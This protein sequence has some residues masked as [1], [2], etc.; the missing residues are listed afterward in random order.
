MKSFDIEILTYGTLTPNIIESSIVDAAERG[1]NYLD[2]NAFMH[3]GEF[4]NLD[5]ALQAHANMAGDDTYC[6][7]HDC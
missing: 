5:A 2:P 1:E 4:E 6:K 3:F 7:Q